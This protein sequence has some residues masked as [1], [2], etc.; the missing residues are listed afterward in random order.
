MNS[1]TGRYTKIEELNGTIKDLMVEDEERLERELDDAYILENQMRKIE[2]RRKDF[3]RLH[4]NS[5]MDAG[6][7]EAASFRVNKVKLPKITIKIFDE[8]PLNWKAF[9]ECFKTVD[10]RQ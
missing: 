4:T 10:R 2:E 3:L 5:N 1:L 6:S 8:N 7:T 9:I